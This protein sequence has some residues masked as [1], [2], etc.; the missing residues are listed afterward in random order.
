[1]LQLLG[2][3]TQ[4][5]KKVLYVLEEIGTPYEFRHIDLFKRENKSE[6]IARLNPMQ[7]V[8]ILIYNGKPLFE[9]GAICRFVANIADSPLYPKD[10]YERALV[11]QWMDFFSNHLGRWMSSLFFQRV[12]RARMNKPPEDAAVREALE[13][14]EVQGKVVDEWLDGREFLTGKLS[15]ADLFG[16]AYVEQDKVCDLSLE[17]LPN[18]MRWEKAIAK[19]P[20]IAR[21][22]KKLES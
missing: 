13:F 11:D 14:I 8:P 18:L 10:A 6:E 1:M 7:K 4:N 22:Q 5:S 3:P 15:I 19:R 21:G 16:F 12:L 9:S 2:Y 17:H 20:A